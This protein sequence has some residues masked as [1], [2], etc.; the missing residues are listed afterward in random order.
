MPY[1]GQARHP[2]ARYDPN[3]WQPA[4]M[5]SCVT[6]GPKPTSNQGEAKKMN[7]ENPAIWD[8]G[9]G[10]YLRVRIKTGCSRFGVTISSDHITI[11]TTERPQKNRANLEIQKELS[12]LFRKRVTIES[13]HKTNKKIL[14]VEGATAREIRDLLSS[15]SR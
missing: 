15:C 7:P 5:I 12:R 9:G 6:G 3:G 8:S 4:G 14:R 1:P 13:G 11:E 10:C 2:S